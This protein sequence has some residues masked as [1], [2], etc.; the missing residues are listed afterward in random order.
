M[1]TPVP[2]KDT[3]YP[4]ASETYQRKSEIEIQREGLEA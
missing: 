4:L 1:G 3:D 2:L